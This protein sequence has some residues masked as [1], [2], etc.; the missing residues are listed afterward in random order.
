[1]K[2]ADQTAENFKH[3]TLTA[4]PSKSA[5]SESEAKGVESQKE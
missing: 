3:L 2:A 1:M 4:K 5:A